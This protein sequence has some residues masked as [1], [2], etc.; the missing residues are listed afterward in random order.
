MKA[1][2]RPRETDAATQGSKSVPDE[3]P[4][5]LQVLLSRFLDDSAVSEDLPGSAKKL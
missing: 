4:A 5:Y 3:M 2:S 1:G